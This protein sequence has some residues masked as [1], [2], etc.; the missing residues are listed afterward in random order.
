MKKQNY[1]TLLIERLTPSYFTEQ[2]FQA[3]KEAGRNPIFCTTLTPDGHD[4]AARLLR[5]AG[6]K[7]RRLGLVAS[8]ELRT[9]PWREV[10][11]MGF[12][13]LCR[14]EMWN[15]GV[16]HWMRDGFDAW[17]ARQMRPPVRMVYGYETE[18]LQTFK[19]AKAAGI[20]TVLDLPSRE[21][22]FVEDL[23]WEEFGKFPGLLTRGRRHFR[24][25]QPGRTARR[26]EEFRLADVVV[27]NST[28]TATSWA[29]AGL[30]ASKIHVVP[31]GAPEPE[32]VGLTGGSNGHGPLRLICAG[33]FSILKGAHYLLRAWENWS[34]GAAAQLD[35]FG[36]VRLPQELLA[37]VPPGV[38]LRGAIH[39][40]QLLEKFLD[41]DLLIFPTLSDGFGLVVT[42]ALSR[43]LPVL[44]TRQ[45]GA[46][47]L[48]RDRENGLIVESRDSSQ[49]EAALDWSLTHREELRAMRGE[50]L[51]T[52]QACQWADYRRNL[53]AA[54]DPFMQTSR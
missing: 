46:A 26:H 31:L 20:H 2:A 41:A 23:L 50:A 19:A 32:P 35:V 47:D 10:V 15:D 25:L 44:T 53:R 27:A 14:D 39:R 6:T 8:H 4:V 45:A 24:E 3:F 18:C 29:V 22:D 51:R 30:D 13:R 7:R 37:S 43:G 11:R 36:T 9:N 28:L 54:L 1:E 33:T 52:A 17:V 38:T 21:H 42:E 48:I 49:L 34:P 5:M 12:G 40:K 16:F